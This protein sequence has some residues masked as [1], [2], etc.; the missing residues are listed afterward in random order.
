MNM[1][2]SGAFRKMKNVNVI[3]PKKEYFYFDGGSN[4]IDGIV[5]LELEYDGRIPLEDFNV[6]N[7]KYEGKILLSYNTIG[8]MG[9]SS[10][11]LPIRCA[12]EQRVGVDKLNRP[13]RSVID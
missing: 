9:K 6:V 8:K 13:I 2:C 5:K 12:I 7:R 1:I 10:C 11:I 3:L 4:N